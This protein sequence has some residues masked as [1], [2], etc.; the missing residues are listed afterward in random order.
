MQINDLTVVAEVTEA[1]QRYERALE[2][3]DTDTLGALFW[4]SHKTIR[5]GMGGEI[6]HGWDEIQSHRKAR[7]GVSTPWRTL[8]D[9]VITSFGNDM[10][11]ASTLFQLEQQPDMVGRQ[12]QTWCR[13][14]GHWCV[15]AAHVSWVQRQ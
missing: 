11:T 3:G 13:L 14:D 6:G 7:I 2:A 5:Y 8:S 4:R 1:F 10:A 15:V 12:M 9:T